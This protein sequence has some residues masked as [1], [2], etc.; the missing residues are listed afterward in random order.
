[1]AI[2]L[3]FDYKNEEDRASFRKVMQIVDPTRSSFVQKDVLM[4][5]FMMP[6][7]IDYIRP[8]EM[9]VMEVE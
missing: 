7:F 4:N 3:N 2:V 8:E 9:K 5:F 1:L 6:G